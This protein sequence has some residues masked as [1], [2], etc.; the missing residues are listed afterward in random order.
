MERMLIMRNASGRVSAGQNRGNAEWTGNFDEATT[1]GKFGP[2]L[3]SSQNLAL[4]SSVSSRSLE[5]TRNLNSTAK[6][7][8]KHAL[9]G[10]AGN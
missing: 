2:D 10:M 3:D 8:M 6:M 4:R 7:N 9:A 5:N 1:T